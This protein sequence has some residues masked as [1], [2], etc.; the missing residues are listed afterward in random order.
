M[1]AQQ[2]VLVLA[3]GVDEPG[4]QRMWLLRLALELRME[5]HRHVPRMVRQLDDL[6]ELP[7]ERAAHHLQPLVRQRLLVEAVEL[8]AMAMTLVD[9]VGAIQTVRERS[10]L[11]LTRI[12]S[13]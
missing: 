2:A 4:E 9:D 12:R 8:V 6:D 13:Q 10:R 5:L 1:R 11:Q 7:V 3:G